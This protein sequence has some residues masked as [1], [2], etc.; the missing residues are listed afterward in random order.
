[1]NVVDTLRQRAS[2][3]PVGTF[4]TV[5]I[6]YSA[7]AAT[8]IYTVLNGLPP[9]LRVAV[10]AWGPMLS[11]GA[12]VWLLDESVRD[13]LG[14]LRNLQ[15]GVHWYLAGVGIMMIGTELET[16]VVLFLGGDVTV[17][18]GPPSTYLFFFDFTLFF[19]GAL[20]ELGWRGFLQ[21]RLQQ[22]FSALWTSAGIGVLWGLW[23]VPM[24]LAGLGDFA[25]FREYMLMILTVSVIYGWLYNTTEAALPVVMITH[26]S[27]NMPPL[28][29]PTGDVPAVFNVLS[30]DAIFY[31]VCALFI[32]L[33]A[34][35]Q[36]LTR[37]GT[38]PKI[39]GHRKESLPNRENPAD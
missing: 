36:T 27:H 24:I 39:P 25:A 29:S 11:A 19:A 38:L 12:T 22:R 2:R 5:L 37:D 30:G 21:P 3:C 4:L 6:V 23:H 32:V 35:S 34:G 10:Y 17:P 13:W 26:A 20:E 16:V 9:M 8:A 28:G 15:T 7:L 31:L 33:Y 1:M 14:Q 18:A